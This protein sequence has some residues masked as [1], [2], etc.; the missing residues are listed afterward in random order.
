MNTK[1]RLSNIKCI[2]L[3]WPQNTKVQCAMYFPFLFLNRLFQISGYLLTLWVELLWV[4]PGIFLRTQ[5]LPPNASRLD[6]QNYHIDLQVTMY[7]R[8]N[9]ECRNPVCECDYETLDCYLKWQWMRQ[10][11]GFWNRIAMK[12]LFLK[13]DKHYIG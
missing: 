3:F 8:Q 4:S 5:V 11:L 7:N 2:T 12:I 9:F 1:P 13:K 6:L 10:F